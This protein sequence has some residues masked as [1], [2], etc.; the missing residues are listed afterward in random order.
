M[1]RRLLVTIVLA[2]LVLWLAGAPTAF[3]DSPVGTAAWQPQTSGVTEDLQSVH[4]V[5][6]S[7]GW[8]A[9]RNATLLHTTN[10]GRTWESVTNTGINPTIGFDSVRFLDE[11][12]GWV[13]GWRSIIRTLNGGRTW[14]GSQYSSNYTDSRYA[15]F[16][17]SPT[18]AW[19]V[20]MQNYCNPCYP[21][22]IRYTLSLDGATKR[23]EA[24][25]E[26]GN[27][28][29]IRDIFFVDADNGWSIASRALDPVN[30]TIFRMTNGS[31][32]DPVIRQQVTGLTQRLNKIQMLDANNGWII[33]EGGTILRTTNGG[34]S[35]VPQASGTTANLRGLHFVDLHRGWVVGAGGLILATSEGGST[36]IQEPSGT[37]KD[38]SSIFFVGSKGFAVG[39]EGT[40]L[41]RVTQTY[42]PVI[43]R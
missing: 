28:Y 8:A 36:W 6:A 30:S 17:I 43:M 39:A 5:N 31:T 16:P 9:G 10:G 14:A 24:W 19:Q 20:G 18:V 7:N 32:A 41:T 21:V 13:G 12:V 22:H 34:L 29:A 25:Y 23:S 1:I 15:T 40:I 37:A 42:L 27:F 11:N 2:G 38:L 35:W 3:S 4:F 33:G 26:G